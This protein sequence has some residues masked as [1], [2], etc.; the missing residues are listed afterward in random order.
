MN[1]SK[2]SDFKTSTDKE[3]NQQSNKLGTIVEDLHVEDANEKE[4]ESD[5]VTLSALRK[6]DLPVSPSEVS[7][8]S[9]PNST[10]QSESQS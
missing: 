3:F 4:L 1:S 5:R 10:T 8:Q 7:P 9:L 2:Q 6:K